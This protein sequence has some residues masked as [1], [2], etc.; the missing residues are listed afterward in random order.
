MDTPAH[1]THFTQIDDAENDS[2][3][4]FGM[5]FSMV[6]SDLEHLAHGL[7]KHERPGHTLGTHGL[8]HE[9]YA[10]L[11]TTYQRTHQLESMTHNDLRS[12]TA[13][14]MRRVLVDHARKRQ[15]RVKANDVYSQCLELSCKQVSGLAIDLITLEES[16]NELETIDPRKARI[17]ELRFFGAMPMTKI[18]GLIN[19]PL[20]TVERDWAF[21]RAWLCER[22]STGRISTGGES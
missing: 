19:C 15:A 2:A 14:V 1:I 21:A 9:A 7:M 18:A 20:R 5:L 8:M 12:L 13:V 10:R 3:S 17:V 22:I 6:Y 4:G 16:L 11:L